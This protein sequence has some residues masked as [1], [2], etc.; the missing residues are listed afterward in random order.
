M[1]VLCLNLKLILTDADAEVADDADDVRD[2]HDNKAWVHVEVAKSDVK[3][4]RFRGC[5]DAK[6]DADVDA[7]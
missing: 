4:C 7:N 6:G 3:V 5:N 2:D 1:V